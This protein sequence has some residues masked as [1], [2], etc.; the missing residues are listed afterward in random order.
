MRGAA[1][2][3]FGRIL[4]YAT[5]GF[6]VF[7]ALTLGLTGGDLSGCVSHAHPIADN[8]VDLVSR[9][10]PTV[11]ADG[12]V[13]TLRPWVL[14]HKDPARGLELTVLCFSFSF[15]FA[16]NAALAHHVHRVYDKTNCR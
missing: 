1:K 3:D 13:E 11:D 4:A 7:M 9:G 6:L 2:R 5:V 16:F 14:E 15:L 8:A 10:V 12:F